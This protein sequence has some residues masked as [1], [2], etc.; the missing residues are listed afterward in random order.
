MDGMDEGLRGSSMRSVRG[1]G[2]MRFLTVTLCLQLCAAVSAAPW[3]EQA[4]LLASDGADEDWIGMSVSKMSIIISK[5]GK[6]MLD[7][8]RMIQKLLLGFLL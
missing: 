6:R 7:F 4:K 5:P 2:G 3:E 1:M 8:L